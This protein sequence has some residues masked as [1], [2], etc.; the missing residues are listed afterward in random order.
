M[1]NVVDFFH[2]GDINT[3]YKNLTITDFI[4]SI[5]K[6]KQEEDYISIYKKI[7]PKLI[8]INFDFRILFNIIYNIEELHELTLCIINKNESVLKHLSSNQIKYLL[9]KTNW[10]KNIILDN[11]ELI[12]N[13]K[14]EKNQK[15]DI[16]V[17]YY[18]N[19]NNIDFILD[20]FIYK[21]NSNL[22]I[23][24]INKILKY[25]KEK[26]INNKN[27]MKTI[28]YENPLNCIFKQE[29]IINIE[30]KPKIIS[31]DNLILLL[32]SYIDNNVPIENIY[33]LCDIILKRYPQNNISQILINN[34]KPEIKK[35]LIDHLE[36]IFNTSI[37]N[38]AKILDIFYK[39]LPRSL[40]DKYKI[41]IKMLKDVKSKTNEH[42]IYYKYNIIINYNLTN[43]IYNIINKYLNKSN[44]KSFKFLNKGTTNHVFQV[45][46]YVLKISD[47]RYCKNCPKHFRIIK[48]EER[49]V[50]NDNNQTPIFY[51]EVQKL[52]NQNKT[53]ITKKLIYK[54]FKDLQKDG[55]TTTDPLTLEYN[56]NNF[57]FLNNYKDAYIDNN[58]SYKL[59][60][61][62]KENPLVL[63]DNDLIYYNHEMKNDFN[64]NMESVINEYEQK[65]LKK[66]FY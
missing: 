24:F 11:I 21:Y 64:I 16:I 37:I 20:K 17:Q 59:P 30:E 36:T 40:I 51:I 15:L 54:L 25:D 39:E 55:I 58:N 8:N 42:L 34:N 2:N 56:P 13:R 29:S 6:I 46:E 65:T 53:K 19:N 49:I 9:D 12:L 45:G 33:Y 50:I 35:Y 48:N 61:Y 63:I 18:L 22:R 57:A 3:I 66:Q 52:L 38:K 4:E 44:N 27:I 28:I 1:I 10:G 31:H 5:N 60:D 47:Y 23:D 14:L 43:Q 32:K 41:L 26:I 7:I 62:F